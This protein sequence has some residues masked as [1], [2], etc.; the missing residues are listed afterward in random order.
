ML[1]KLNEFNQF[2]ADKNVDILPYDESLQLQHITGNGVVLEKPVWYDYLLKPNE[3]GYNALVGYGVKKFKS[4]LI[5][6][7][8]YEQIPSLV[9]V[10]DFQDFI[11]GINET[12]YRYWDL[13][14]Q[15]NN[16]YHN[17]DEDTTVT[18]T[19]GETITTNNIDE[20][21]TTQD[22]DDT[23]ST[24]KVGKYGQD[25]NTLKNTDNSEITTDGRQDVTT[26][27]SAEDKITIAEHTDS[28]HTVRGGNIGVT[29]NKT[30][31]FEHLEYASMM[32]LYE[33]FWKEYLEYFGC[34]V[35]GC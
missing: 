18:T 35:W 8:D 22:F 34:S 15:K 10:A 12:M 16:P 13:F 21:K 28:V 6:S 1:M 14:T 3:S 32:K 23:K 27:D 19:Y 20:R 2:L 31:A 24:E 30:L 26:T 9:Y 17:V 25:S 7:S 5:D 33:M 11:Y 29:T 4:M